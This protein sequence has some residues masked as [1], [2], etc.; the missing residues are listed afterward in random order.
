MP[1]TKLD[2]DKDKT[3]QK[4]RKSF[5]LKKYSVHLFCIC[6]NKSLLI[7]LPK[8]EVFAPIHPSSCENLEMQNNTRNLRKYYHVSEV[9]PNLKTLDD[10]ARPHRVRKS[11]YGITP[12][13][14]QFLILHTRT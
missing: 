7:N 8:T 12:T 10:N 14:D 5:Y 6:N 4:S 9:K 3:K 1:S 11:K 2:K 13:D